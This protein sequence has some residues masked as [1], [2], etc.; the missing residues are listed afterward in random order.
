MSKLKIF[1]VPASRAVRTLW[2]AQE[3]GLDYEH[4]PVH[5]AGDEIKADSYR[6]INPNSRI[7]AIVDGDLTL[8]ESMAIN[9]Y[10]ARKHGGPLQPK[11]LADEARALQ[12][13]FWV[14]TEVEKSTLA[15]LFQA[16]APEDKRKP[17][18]VAASTEELQRPFGVLNEALS[19]SPYLLGSDFTVAD[20]NVASVL[21]WAKMAKLDLSAWPHLRDWLNRC[22]SR[23]A[24]Q[25]ARGQ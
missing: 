14:M 22:T 23:P 25:A 18:V 2:M 7:P 1:G 16:M 24:L 8:W 21:T 17:E 13:S 5:F 10:L 20:L 3:L 11:T 6:R 4:N 9:L 12:W 19:G 15:L